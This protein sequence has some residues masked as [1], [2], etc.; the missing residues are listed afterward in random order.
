VNERTLITLVSEGAIAA[1]AWVSYSPTK[2]T[3]STL[4]HSFYHLTS[5]V[6]KGWVQKSFK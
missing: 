4:F 2:F 6:G 1:G 3:Y 5:I